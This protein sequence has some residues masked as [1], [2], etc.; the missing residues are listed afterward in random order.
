MQIQSGYA[1][2]CDDKVSAQQFLKMCKEKKFVWGYGSPIKASENEILYIWKNADTLFIVNDSFY[3]GKKV[4]LADKNFANKHK[5]YIVNV[6][7]K[8]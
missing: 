8:A 1:Y 7:A 4:F 3:D 5:Y 2:K 6:E